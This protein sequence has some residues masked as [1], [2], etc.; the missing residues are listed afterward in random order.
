MAVPGGWG[1][2]TGKIAAIDLSENIVINEDDYGEFYSGIGFFASWNE[3]TTA[4]MRTPWDGNTTKLATFNAA[5]EVIEEF[6]IENTSLANSTG[7]LQNMFYAV[8]NNGIG[9]FDLET[10]ELTNAAVVMPQEMSIG[11]SVLDTVNQLFYLTTTDFSSTGSGFIYNMSGESAGTFEAGISAQAIAIDYRDNTAIFERNIA[12]NLDV[13]PNPATQSIHF[14]I[15][16]NQKATD[17][18]VLDISGR[19]VAYGQNVQQMDVNE[20]NPGL[21]FIT[22]KTETRLRTGKFIKQ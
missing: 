20:L 16:L 22:V 17:V 15:P 3:V 2:T 13:Y 4:F 1:S 19:I 8:V 14:N 5:G 9:V 6:T 21:Y 12:E 11:A 18:Y 10:S 7:Q